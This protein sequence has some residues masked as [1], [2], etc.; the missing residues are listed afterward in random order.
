[1]MQ[2]YEQVKIVYNK[3]PENSED[4]IFNKY[5]EVGKPLENGIAKLIEIDEDK[6]VIRVRL[7]N[8]QVYVYPMASME[9]YTFVRRGSP[10]PEDF[11]YFKA[12]KSLRT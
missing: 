11:D 4:P 3:P 2:T 10:V 6:Y 12:Q 7:D 8:N 5:I 1:M 9:Y